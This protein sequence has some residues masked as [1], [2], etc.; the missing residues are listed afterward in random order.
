MFQYRN[1][2][3]TTT[4]ET[5]TKMLLGK[6][7]RYIFDLLK[8][9]NDDIVQT[10]QI[11]QIKN[12]GKRDATFKLNEKVLVRDYRFP[13]TKWKLATI[14]KILGTR[15]YQV[16]TDENVIWKRHVDQIIKNKE[17]NTNK[18]ILSSSLNNDNPI[19]VKT[20]NINDNEQQSTKVKS[21]LISQ[22]P[23]RTIIQPNKYND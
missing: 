19:S 15:N 16:T 17:L 2:P 1:T 18:S 14:T 5:P 23:K 22:R 4:N 20:P 11:K 7:V 21:N 9:Y 10:K 13:I 12:S 3:H 6:S 8:P